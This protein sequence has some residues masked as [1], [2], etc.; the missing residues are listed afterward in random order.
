MKTIIQRLSE[1]LG[2]K[3]LSP[4]TNPAK[5]WL[6]QKIKSLTPSS[7]TRQDILRQREQ[8]RNKTIIG[9]MYFFAYSAKLHETLPYWD[10]FP[11]VIP[12]QRYSDGFLGLNLHYIRPKD[13]LI[14]LKQLS[15]FATGALDDERTRLR[16]SYPILTAM[17]HAYR[18][19]P[20]IKRYLAGHIQSRIIEIPTNEWDIAAALPLHQFTSKDMVTP[21]D[22][23]EESEEK[24]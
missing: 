22:V 5:T 10:K 7:K 17:H 13:R 8:Q 9:R 18:A 6:L 12:L 2:K 21:Q 24:F 19:T 11:L 15:Q 20:C 4:G 23:W 3:G 16:L 1:E 14:L